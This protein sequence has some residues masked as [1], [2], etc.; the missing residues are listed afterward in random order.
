VSCPK[1]VVAIRVQKQ[2]ERIPDKYR[3][4]R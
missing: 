3:C 4:I 1:E 2:M